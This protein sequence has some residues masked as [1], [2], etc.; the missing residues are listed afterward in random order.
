V[1]FL[2]KE[3]RS[4]LMSRIRS[5]S[6]LELRGRARAELR[7]GCRLSHGTRKRCRT[8]PGTPDWYSRE[9][10]VAVFIHGCFWHGCPL[11]YTVPQTN[12]EYWERKVAGNRRRDR[13]TAR[14]FRRMGWRV[15]N[16]W[17]HSLKTT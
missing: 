17:E 15:I 11:H 10:M 16:I 1:D 4:R 2:T 3:Q 6:K 7:A 13:R 14:A 8:L 5:V 12:A 9:G